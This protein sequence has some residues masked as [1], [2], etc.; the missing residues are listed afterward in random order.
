MRAKDLFEANGMDLI[1]MRDM[2]YALADKHGIRPS[3]DV[4]DFF[5]D[6][7][8]AEGYGDEE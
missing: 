5:D 7:L 3:D 1:E 8:T 2:F 4:A 6:V